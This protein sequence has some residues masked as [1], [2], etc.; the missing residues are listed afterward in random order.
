MKATLSK[1]I[2]LSIVLSLFMGCAATSKTQGSRSI[3][4]D[5]GISY[6][7]SVTTVGTEVQ[8]SLSQRGTTRGTVVGSH[9]FGTYLVKEN[10][11]INYFLDGKPID[12]GVVAL[13]ANVQ[14]DKRTGEGV[15]ILWAPNPISSIGAFMFELVRCTKGCDLS[16]KGDISGFLY[17]GIISG[18][19]DPPVTFKGLTLGYY[20]MRL[21]EFR[22]ISPRSNWL[23]FQVK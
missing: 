23:V 15:Q 5:L 21:Y 17:A 4:K 20:A 10:F 3:G 1:T 18:P 19:V 11:T 8:Y 14:G 9:G 2:V 7:S 22:T 12:A 13:T 16:T 6:L